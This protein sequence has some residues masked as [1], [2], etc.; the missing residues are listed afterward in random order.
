MRR[1]LSLRNPQ[2]TT[3]MQTRNDWHHHLM[4]LC[5]AKLQKNNVKLVKSLHFFKI[6]CTCLLGLIFDFKSFFLLFRGTLQKWEIFYNTN[7]PKNLRRLILFHFFYAEFEYVFII[8]LPDTTSKWGWI[9]CV[10]GVSH[11][12]ILTVKIHGPSKVRKCCFDLWNRCLRRE[13]PMQ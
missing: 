3:G 10:I 4:T 7:C 6:I 5:R 8:F 11:C 12:K 13:R 9:L 2:T 1:P